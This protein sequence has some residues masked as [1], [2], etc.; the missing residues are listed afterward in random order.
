MRAGV[1]L[2]RSIGHRGS[3]P[4]GPAI[5]AAILEG[6]GDTSVVLLAGVGR[7]RRDLADRDVVDVE[8]IRRAAGLDI[9]YQTGGRA[10][11]IAIAEIALYLRPRR[12]SEEHTSE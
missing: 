4:R 12:R 2:R 9:Q 7:R 3:R 5:H 11:D 8:G 1:R 6:R 10:W